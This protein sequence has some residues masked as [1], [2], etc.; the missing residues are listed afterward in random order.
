MAKETFVLRALS[1]ETA[2]EMSPQVGSADIFS[3]V[4]VAGGR[5]VC[6]L[7]VCVCE[8]VLLVLQLT[9][10]VAGSKCVCML[11]VGV[12]AYCK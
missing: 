1:F 9:M 7:E 5:Y 11:W 8:C 12:S 2:F 3:Y 10:V 6:M 4:A